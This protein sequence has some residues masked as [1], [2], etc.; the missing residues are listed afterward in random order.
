MI[1]L[2]V[3]D[4]RHSLYASSTEMQLVVI[5]SSL[6]SLCIHTTIPDNS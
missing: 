4:E 5:D 3:H 2:T 6:Q 1:L